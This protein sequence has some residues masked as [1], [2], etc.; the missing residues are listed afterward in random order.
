MEFSYPP[1][2]TQVPENLT[3]PSSS[4]RK[5]AW[6]ASLAVLAFVGFYLGFT[7]WIAYTS[8][9]LFYNIFVS[10]DGGFLSFVVG[11]LMAFLTVFLVKAL[12]FILRKEETKNHEI[13]EQD[14]PKL[15]DF[16]HRLADEIGAP[17][18]Q[19][20]YLS[21]PVNASV[22][23]DLSILNLFF[24]SKKNLN[25]GLGLINVL[26]L[27]EF[28]A[29]LAHEFGHFSQRSMLVGRWVY[30]AHRIAQGIVEKRDAL[31]D[32]LRGLSMLDIRIAWLGWL[33]LMIVWSIRSTVEL[34][35]R[36]VVI[37]ERALSRE[38]EF[39]ADLVAVSVTGSDALINALSRTRPA[40]QAFSNAVATANRFLEKKQAIPNL[41]TLQAADI[42]H[43]GRVLNID[44]Y[45]KSPKI[46]LTDVANFRVFE[47]GIAHPPKMWET[48]PADHEREENVK[49]TYIPSSI[50]S[51]SAWDLFANAE[52]TQ[53]ELTAELLKT[54]KVETTVIS[55]KVSMEAH[56]EM[57]RA[58][59]LQSKYRGAFLNRN[60]FRNYRDVSEAYSSP[61]AAEKL[62]P[63]LT[64]IYP[65]ALEEMLEQYKTL[66]D[67]WQVL[68]AIQE[69]ILHAPDGVVQHRGTSLK[70][71]DLPQAIQKVKA[72]FEA[73]QKLV[74]DHDKLCR[75]VH[76]EA[77]KK[78]G[79]GWP[80][81]LRGL[82]HL[83]HYN[84]HCIAN[85]QDVIFYFQR[86]L[87]VVTATEHVSDGELNRLLVAA[88][89]VREVLRKIYLQIPEVHLPSSL[90]KE[91]EVESWAKGLGDFKLDGA[92]SENINSWLQV[93]DSWINPVMLMMTEARSAALQEL[94]QSEA[95]VA[96]CFLNNQMAERPAPMPATVPSGY[97]L[98]VPGSER[99]VETELSAWN[100]FMAAD[101]MLPTIAR[102]AAA[103]A[104]IGATIAAVFYT[105]ANTGTEIQIYNGLSNSVSVQMGKQL[106]VVEPHAA[107]QVTLKDLHHLHVSTKTLE[108][109]PIESFDPYINAASGKF[110]YNVA[111]AATLYQWTAFYGYEGTS[112]DRS[113]GAPRWLKNKSDYY[114]EEPPST[115]STSSSSRGTRRTVL[116]AISNENPLQM[117]S[118]VESEEIQ[119]LLIRSHV[120]FDQTGSK[121]LLSWITLAERYPW[122]RDV[123]ESRL[124]R[125]PNEIISWRSLQ[126]VTDSTEKQGVCKRMQQYSEAEPDNPDW[127]Y[128]TTRCLP[129]GP[130][131]H[132]R[133][134]AG[135]ERWSDHSWLG[136]AAGHLYGAQEDWAKAHEAF[137]VAI[138][139]GPGFESALSLSMDRIRRIAKAE[140]ININKPLIEE[141]PYVQIGALLETAHEDEIK[142]NAY[143]PYWL[144][145]QGRLDDAIQQAEAGFIKDDIMRKVA[146][147]DG[148]TEFQ[149]QQA[150][151]L[152]E[153]TATGEAIWSSL[154]VLV[155]QGEDL[156]SQR[157]QLAEVAREEDVVRV[158]DFVKQIR[159]GQVEAAKESMKK[160]SVNVKGELAVLGLIVLKDKAPERWRTVAKHLLYGQERP[161]LE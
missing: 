19:K 109:L 113:L 122:V 74:E 144:L 88:N 89:R 38:M 12:F 99:K 154:G 61:I 107:T 143:Y 39:H 138:Q 131:Q 70:K 41:Y 95:Y 157:T 152:N 15:F 136:L 45:G 161:Y 50:D 97:D 11:L 130:E 159:A 65:K 20:V 16:I 83:I 59:Y 124:E 30:T 54:A 114:F 141:M 4:Y 29:V 24:P 21:N 85:T 103:A 7:S 68:E 57:Y 58:T 22:F 51:R 14:E 108:G 98:M 146:L 66:Q 72:E 75:S 1:G 33:L 40:D 129:D 142:D 84:E 79:N 155:Q 52:K 91:M 151:A 63:S 17:R 137:V 37:A 149:I 101:G 132:T 156:S 127:Y 35:F 102:A 23:Y 56:L 47:K 18:P 76:M 160:A 153:N 32:F 123:L 60:L 44:G 86:V 43:T 116:S 46:P 134:I 78:L 139:A 42:E 49:A 112:N 53:L 55:E 90:L 119:E 140:G 31:D 120:K 96:E 128:L 6:I 82:I 111:Q 80:E 115:M 62:R 125:Y 64:A 145:Q 100:R 87:A 13:T 104:I 93:I 48:H 8:Y 158:L 94:L 25:I 3:V 9:R 118:M 150:I 28:K 77:A 26:S 69:K 71:Q 36:M 135:F 81:Y 92:T 2:P 148:A 10:D 67:E 106:V 110:I 5:Q 126:D 147:S 27:G 73:T 133:F 121:D 117:V 105:D 34:F